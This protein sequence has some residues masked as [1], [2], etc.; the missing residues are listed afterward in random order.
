MLVGSLSLSLS[1][2]LPL[3]LTRYRSFSHSRT[4]QHARPD[5]SVARRIVSNNDWVSCWG[6]CQVVARLDD[7]C[8][9]SL[10]STRGTAAMGPQKLGAHNGRAGRVALRAKSK[11]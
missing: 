2:S 6:A 11:A 1:F 3:L 9:G 5:V 7:G 8:K 10:N 4:Q